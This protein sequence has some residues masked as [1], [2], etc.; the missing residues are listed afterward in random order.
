MKTEKQIQHVIQSSSQH[1]IDKAENKKLLLTE[2]VPIVGSEDTRMPSIDDPIP[3]IE[4]GLYF[5]SDDYKTL[6]LCTEAEITTHLRN[7]IKNRSHYLRTEAKR[8]QTYVRDVEYTGGLKKHTYTMSPWM[9]NWYK[10]LPTRVAT[11][12]ALTVHITNLM[13]FMSHEIHKLTDYEII[14]GAFHNERIAHFEVY[15]S[16]LRKIDNHYELIRNK[17]KPEDKKRKYQMAGFGTIGV[18][19]Y[20]ELAPK[21]VYSMEIVDTMKKT[22]DEKTQA[23]GC[24]PPDYHIACKID[25]LLLN[26]LVIPHGREAYTV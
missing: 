3:G 2:Y 23:N 12:E 24:L 25:K 11:P 13:T 16:H 7:E 1:Q 22:I 15:V 5:K 10:K 17:Y 6:H 18:M 14:G 21:Q 20:N 26:K 9:S 19:R 8:G 4:N